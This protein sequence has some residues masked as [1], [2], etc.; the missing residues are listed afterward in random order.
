MVPN[1]DEDVLRSMMLIID[2][3]CQIP[4]RIVHVSD[5]VHLAA[6]EVTTT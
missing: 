5:N 2:C 6:A 1:Y 4:E 3:R